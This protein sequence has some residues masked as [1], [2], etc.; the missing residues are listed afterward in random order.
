VAVHASGIDPVAVGLAMG[1][2]T[3]AYRARTL[4]LEEATGLFPAVPRAA[5]P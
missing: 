1:M 3:W 2:L 5:D 4:D